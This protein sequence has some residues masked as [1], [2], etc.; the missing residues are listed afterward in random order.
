M[1]NYTK[2]RAYKK[3]R[4]AVGAS[5]WE[6]VVPLTLSID[7]DGTMRPI[8]LENPSEDCGYTPPIEPMYKWVN[9]DP[10]VDWICDEP[11][12]PTPPAPTPFDGKFRAW[13]SDNTVYSV[14]CGSSSALTTSVTRGHSTAY[15][16]MTSAQVGDCV[17]RIE[18]R[19][20]SGCSSLLLVTIPS[21]VTYIGYGSFSDCSNLSSLILHDEITSIGENA[22]ANCNSLTTVTLPSGLTVILDETFLECYNLSSIEIPNSVSAIMD[23][24]FYVSSNN[25]SVTSSVT[26]G[27]GVTSIG[28][29]AFNGL[30]ALSSI[31]IYATTPPTLGTNSIANTNDCPIYVPSQSL[32]SYRAASGWSYYSSRIQSIT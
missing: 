6:D 27:S 28:N 9:L 11:L 25:Q 26:I 5:T 2:Y 22:C 31:T 19:A 15:S 7:G 20:F 8:V 3:Q 18:D 12:N 14:S 29:N 10:S 24:A 21:S 23:R 13:Y 16:A 17:N 32:S 4:R 1:P 30:R